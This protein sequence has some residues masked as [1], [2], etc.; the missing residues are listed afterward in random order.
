MIKKL[1]ELAKKFGKTIIYVIHQPSSDIFKKMDKLMLLYKGKT[2]YFGDAG[3]PAVDHFG[4][5]GF[6]CDINTNPSDFF[7]YIMQSK[8]PDLENYLTGEYSRKGKVA[9]DSTRKMAIKTDQNDFPGVGTQFSALLSRSVKMTLRNPAQTFIRVA[10]V[11][12]M[13]FFFCSVFFQLSDDVNDPVGIFNRT[14][15]LFFASVSNFIPPMMAQLITCKKFN[16][17]NLSNFFSPC[18]KKSICQRVQK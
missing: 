13:S 14:G 11:L 6:E 17:T 2:I 10:Q 3:Q 4:S 1:D 15:A 12:V 16:Y 8:N 18:R 5:I 9:I 7:M